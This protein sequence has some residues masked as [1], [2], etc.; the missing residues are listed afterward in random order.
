MASR[1]YDN[2]IRLYTPPRGPGVSFGGHTRVI[3]FIPWAQDKPMRLKDK[4][5]DHRSE[6]GSK[7]K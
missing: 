1:K 4:V 3:R 6:A 7:G 5:K 2:L